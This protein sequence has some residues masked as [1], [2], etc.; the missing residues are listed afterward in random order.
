MTGCYAVLCKV[1]GKL[2][3]DIQSRGL[4]VEAAAIG[5]YRTVELQKLPASG[6]RARRSLA[7]KRN[8]SVRSPWKL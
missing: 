6:D 5:T 1:L 2:W 3:N 4:E 8:H 7:L